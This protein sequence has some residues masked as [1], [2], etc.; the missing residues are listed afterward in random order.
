MT[1]STS[2]FTARIR[3]ERRRAPTAKVS[4]PSVF[5]DL[6]ECTRSRRAPHEAARQLLC[7]SAIAFLSGQCVVLSRSGN[8]IGAS[9]G[10]T[11]RSAAACAR[12]RVPKDWWSALVGQRR[13]PLR[14]IFSISAP[15][16]ERS[17][18]NEPGRAVERRRAPTSKVST[19]PVFSD[20]SP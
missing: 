10:L 14:L 19:P 8:G 20:L 9:G 16:R 11:G 2:A 13:L 1:H 7:Q 17:C 18:F 6:S 3:M 4:T 12:A 5:W 15:P